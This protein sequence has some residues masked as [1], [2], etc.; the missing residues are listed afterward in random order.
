[1]IIY[2]CEIKKGIAPKGQKQIGIEYCGGWRDFDNMGISVI[3]VFDYKEGRYRVFMDDNFDEFQVLLDTSQVIVGFN[4]RKFDD[5]LLGAS[6]LRIDK[7]KSYD[8]LAE[9]WKAAD[10]DPEI[11][12]PSTHGGY[13]LGDCCLANFGVGKKGHGEQ[14]PLLYQMGRYG[15]LI[16]YCLH[17]IY[18]TK[19]L[20]EK[21]VR[22]GS[23]ISPRSWVGHDYLAVKKPPYCD[24]TEPCWGPV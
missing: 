15:E 8:L 22:T 23:I 10:L 17:D 7:N 18:M 12:V 3:G 6:G 2:D 1:M 21:V 9:I 24:G 20:L 14:A 5:K 4:N 19:M 13:G 11:F 16:D